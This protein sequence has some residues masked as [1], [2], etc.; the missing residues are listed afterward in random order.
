MVF[1]GRNS[2]CPKS[3]PPG[4]KEKRPRIKIVQFGNVQ[5]DLKR[6]ITKIRAENF[7]FLT[8]IRVVSDLLVL[9]LQYKDINDQHLIA[10]FLWVY[11]TRSMYQIPTEFVIIL[12]EHKGI[13]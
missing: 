13:L 11:E 12:K 4:M 2:N 7:C 6:L 10:S 9:S 5:P 1:R 3:V 8:G